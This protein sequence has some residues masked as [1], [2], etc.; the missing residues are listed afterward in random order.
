MSRT[1]TFYLVPISGIIRSQHEYD[2]DAQSLTDYFHDDLVRII[3]DL[4]K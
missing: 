3:I 1:L 2:K 4:I